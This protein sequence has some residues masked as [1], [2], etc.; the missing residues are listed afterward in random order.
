MQAI[1]DETNTCRVCRGEGKNWEWDYSQV[2]NK[3]VQK[4]SAC[5]W[6]MGTG[7]DCIVLGGF[8]GKMGS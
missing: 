6:C 8:N 4:V 1:I 3:D 5:K 7:Y 2:A